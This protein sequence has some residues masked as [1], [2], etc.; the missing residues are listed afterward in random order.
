M[1]ARDPEMIIRRA[2]SQARLLQGLDDDALATAEVRDAASEAAGEIAVAL[3]QLL[4]RV[5]LIDD[6][7]TFAR[8]R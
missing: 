1:T 4:E 8:G 7:V 3:E 6:R 2:A 5:E